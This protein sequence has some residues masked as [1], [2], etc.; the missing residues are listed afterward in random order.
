MNKRMLK[1]LID[2]SK[3]K[4]R[5]KKSMRYDDVG[6]YFDS[7]IVA[8]DMKNPVYTNGIMLHEFI[9]YTLIQSAGIPVDL[10]DAFDTDEDA[11]DRYP[12]EYKL[13][14]RYHRM[15]NNVE[16]HFIENMGLDWKDYQR[17]V[18][19]VKVKVN[20]QKNKEVKKQIKRWKV[21]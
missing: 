12:E 19:S 10:I 18:Y 7:T 13:Y 17:A 15:A 2:Y 4:F 1:R 21:R 20:S 5:V 3:L 6:D 16:R 14:T 8:Y 11:A 9:E